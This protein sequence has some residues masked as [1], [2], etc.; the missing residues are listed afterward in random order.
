MKIHNGLPQFAIF[1]QENEIVALI[2]LHVIYKYKYENQ[3]Q[4]QTKHHLSLRQLLNM[5]G[6]YT[7]EVNHVTKQ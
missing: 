2:C 7:K 5:I 6:W 3:F 4:T 1:I